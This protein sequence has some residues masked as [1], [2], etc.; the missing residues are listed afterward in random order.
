M[1]LNVNWL[2][3]APYKQ[4]LEIFLVMGRPNQLLQKFQL[5][6]G[7]KLFIIS[8]LAPAEPF[9]EIKDSLT[10]TKNNDERIILARYKPIPNFVDLANN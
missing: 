6:N 1:P 3:H 5:P 10:A 2:D 4:Q 8:V 9:K 7:Q